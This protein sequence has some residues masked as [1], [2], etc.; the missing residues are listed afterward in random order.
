MLKKPFLQFVMILLSGC[1]SSNLIAQSGECTPFFTFKEGTQW[2]M[3]SFNKRDK[4][5]SK[6]AYK[7]IEVERS[8]GKLSAHVSSTVYD[9]K[10][11]V[12]MDMDYWMHCEDGVYSVDLS[13]VLG[14]DIME[15]FE[16]MNMEIEGDPLILPSD[17][18]VGMTLPDATTTMKVSSA[19][20]NIMSTDVQVTDRKVVDKGDVE[21]PAGTFE[22]YEIKSTQ[23]IEAGFLNKEYDYV[24]YYAPDVGMVRSE[25]YDRKGKLDSYMVLA[26]FDS[27]K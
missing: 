13:S 9:K 24:E 22:A 20:I 14:A 11:K 18:S 19:G 17:L 2:E 8:G 12:L 16:D 15:G 3:H 27:G 7:I 1:L 6:M 25:T 4:L 21:V 10:D 5:E 23:K 26:D